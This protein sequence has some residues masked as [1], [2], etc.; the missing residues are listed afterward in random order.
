MNNLPEE[1]TDDLQYCILDNSNPADPDYY[2]R[3]LIFLE[4]FNAPAL[5]L[6][7]G[8]NIIKMPIV[9][10]RPWSIVIGDPEIGELEV[11]SG[12]S[13]N[14]RG[15]QAFV[16]NPLSDFR[17]TFMEIEVVD[18]YQEI[19]WFFPKLQSGWLLATPLNDEPKSPCVFLGKEISRQSEI[20]NRGEVS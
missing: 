18:I 6:S 11:V 8:G 16:F 15:L 7:I 3:Q 5:V 2:F 14:D 12:T 19:S 17:A 1:L 20:I 13:I 9:E 10:N 4:K